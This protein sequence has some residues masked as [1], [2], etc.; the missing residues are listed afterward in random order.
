[1]CIVKDFWVLAGVMSW[2]SNCIRI[3]E[4]GVF[5]NISFY[6]SWI[7]KSAVSYADLSAT[8]RSDFSRFF[9]VMLLPLI[10]LG[11]P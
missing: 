11:P 10:F 3:N 6:K 8:P 5:T 9:P 4:P 1:M 2:G 7:E